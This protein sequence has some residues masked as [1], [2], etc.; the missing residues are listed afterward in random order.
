M[1]THRHTL[2][3]LQRIGCGLL[4]AASI[5]LGACADMDDCVDCGGCGLAGG[6]GAFD[7][8]HSYQAGLSPEGDPAVVVRGRRMHQCVP[9]SAVTVVLAPGGAVSIAGGDD[10]DV[11]GAALLESSD[12]SIYAFDGSGAR[13]ALTWI[14]LRQALQIRFTEDADETVV[15]CF[16][17]ETGPVCGIMP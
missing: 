9:D 10:V 1:R 6:A 15:D 12:A 4:A 14:D 7:E 5:A 17:S 11:D 13:A 16:P 8:I 2:A 3:W